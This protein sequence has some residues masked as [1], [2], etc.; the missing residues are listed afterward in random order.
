MEGGR[1][2]GESEKGD[3]RNLAFADEVFPSFPSRK[4]H[5]GT[6]QTQ[7][8]LGEAVCAAKF[9]SGAGCDPWPVRPAQPSGLST[10][11]RATS[12]PQERAVCLQMWEKTSWEQQTSTQRVV[13]KIRTCP[14]PQPSVLGLHPAEA[15]ARFSLGEKMPRLTTCGD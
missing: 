15:A 12:Q 1:E 2:R 7:A 10:R 3:T 6:L 11:L 8:P 4:W 5:H 13:A 14:G 9:P